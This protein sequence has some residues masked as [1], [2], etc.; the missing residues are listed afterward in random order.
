MTGVARRL[1]IAAAL[2]IPLAALAL[3]APAS[4]SP[5]SHTTT[6]ATGSVVTNSVVCTVMASDATIRQSP[7]GAILAYTFYEDR[8]RIDDPRDGVWV[9]GAGYRPNG[10][11]I[12]YGYILRQYLSC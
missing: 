6:N 4:A 11:L 8:F 2:A 7:G 10:T 5:P 12:A 1:W 9:F 3:T